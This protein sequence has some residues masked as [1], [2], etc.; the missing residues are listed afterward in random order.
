MSGGRDEAW[1]SVRQQTREVSECRTA[2]SSIPCLEQLLDSRI[3]QD[4]ELENCWCE[5]M[6][7]GIKM[8]SPFG[9]LAK[10]VI[11]HP[12]IYLGVKWVGKYRLIPNPNPFT[13]VT[14]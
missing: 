4:L 11:S 6:V 14:G 9:C 8:S 3:L 12:I 10:S 13:K 2:V 1:W 5:K 7:I